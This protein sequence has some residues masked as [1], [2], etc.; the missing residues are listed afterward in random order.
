[1]TID[2]TDL[3]QFTGI[4]ASLVA[5]GLGFK[6]DAGSLRIALTGSH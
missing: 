5:R 3:D 4:I 6:A 2:C 1:M